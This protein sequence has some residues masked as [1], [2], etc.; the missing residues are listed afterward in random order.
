MEPPPLKRQKLDIEDKDLE[1]KSPFDML[2]NEMAEIPIKM[3]MKCLTTQDRYKFLV[4][5]LPKVSRR[6]RDIA[7]H[8]PMWKDFSPFEMLPDNLAEIP[9]KMAVNGMHPS[10]RTSF[11]VNDLAKASTRFQALSALK[12]L[13]KNYIGITG[14]TQY[15]RH[16]IQHYVNDDTTEI[17][18]TPAPGIGPT[19]LSPEDVTTL[20]ARCP[21][22]R[23]FSLIGAKLELWPDF[24]SPWTS[25]KVLFLLHREYEG[26]GIKHDKLFE[27]VKLHHSLPNLEQLII[28]IM[29]ANALP[30]YSSILVLPDM[31]QCKFLHTLNLGQGQYYI[32]GLPNDLKRLSGRNFIDHDLNPVIINMERKSFKE[33]YE[34]CK[35]SDNIVWEACIRGHYGCDCL[36]RVL[37]CKD[38]VNMNQ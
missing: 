22:L 18:I 25:L 23:S 27:N 13:W 38:P 34:A 5:D 36:T 10:E 16:V 1:G 8:K 26:Y 24:V 30:G 7:N 15:V 2:P 17:I 12:S 37:T 21:K 35:V 29:A 33:K 20:A 31:G 32:S 6:F 14:R 28:G 19:I 3:A 4:N 11:L 9:I